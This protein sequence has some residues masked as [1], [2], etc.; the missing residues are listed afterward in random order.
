[1]A[2][3][4]RVYGPCL[5]ADRVV[6]S[7]SASKVQRTWRV[8]E[9]SRVGKANTTS[10]AT[11]I[12]SESGKSVQMVAEAT[13]ALNEVLPRIAEFLRDGALAE[14]D[15]SLLVD[16]M[17]PCSIVLER[18]TLRVIE[19]YGVRLVISAYPVEEEDDVPSP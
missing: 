19:Q 13:E 12:L 1:V 11:L 16:A 17:Q 10:G 14:I 8:G 7:V 15:F 9:M 4:L 6:G 2:A 18:E 5:D 3:V